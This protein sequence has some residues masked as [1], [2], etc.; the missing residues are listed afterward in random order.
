MIAIAKVAEKL[1]SLT[2][3]LTPSAHTARAAAAFAT[4]GIRGNVEEGSLLVAF[5][6]FHIHNLHPSQVG[7]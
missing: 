1:F 6:D 4:A 3:I 7:G 5:M 2:S